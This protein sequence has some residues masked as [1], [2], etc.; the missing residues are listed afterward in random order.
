M[1]N[2]PPSGIGDSSKDGVERGV[3]IVNHWVEY[4][5]GSMEVNR[6]VEYFFD[7]DF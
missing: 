1:Q 4:I 2:P 6:L 5:G 3:V 7:S